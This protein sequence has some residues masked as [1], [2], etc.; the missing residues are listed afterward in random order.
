[1]ISWS[2]RIAAAEQRVRTPL[3]DTT[4]AG[5]KEEVDAQATRNDTFGDF[6][7]K[8]VGI[9]LTGFAI[10]QGAPFWFALLNSSWWSARP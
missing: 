1:M 8:L 4:G 5:T 2:N 3:Q 9:L 10:S 7:L 6:F